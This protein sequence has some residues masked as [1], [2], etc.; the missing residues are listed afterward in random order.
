MQDTLTIERWSDRT[1]PLIVAAAFAPFVVAILAAD[2]RETV[3]LIAD[4]AS[5]SVFFV[6]LVVRLFIDRRYLRSG[7]GVFDLTIVL[8]TFPWYL[9]PGAQGAEFLLVF[10]LAR[11][12]RV[13]RSTDFFSSMGAALR[14]FGGLGI[15]II[16]ATL[17]SAQMVMNAEPPESGYETFGD[18]LWWAVVSLTT[19][20]YG[21]LFPVTPFGRMAGVI[22]MLTGLAALGSVAAILSSMFMATGSQDPAV[23]DDD[24]DPDD[25]S[26]EV[27]EQL[28]ALRA[29]VA[30][31]KATIES[32]SG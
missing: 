24:D 16:G 9:I 6:D 26:V 30:D 12:A 27:A 25:G 1:R 29:E 14:R 7:K 3:F 20:G 21:D 32:S 2:S 5:W 28:R 31:L 11:L 17:F 15:W 23:A 13:M 8:V 4:F 18:A 22:M 19:V 10:R